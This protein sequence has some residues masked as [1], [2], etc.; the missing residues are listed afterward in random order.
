MYTSR[1]YDIE[2]LHNYG[3]GIDDCSLPHNVSTQEDIIQM[4]NQL[5][6]F[7]N[8]Y[9]SLQSLLIP[10]SVTIARSSLDD[11][12]P[13]D[14]V[15]FIQEGVISKVKTYFGPEKIKSVDLCYDL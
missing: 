8:N 14:Q 12:C 13:S 6:N 2:I 3:C 9:F 11:Y 4:L 7:L 10:G 5:T 15:D 1:N